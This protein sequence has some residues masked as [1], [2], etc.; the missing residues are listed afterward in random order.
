MLPPT[1]TATSPR[2]PSSRPPL[3]LL[4]LALSCWPLNAHGPQ[5]AL[6]ETSVKG[7]QERGTA[8]TSA[9]TDR[10][11]ADRLSPRQPPAPGSAKA[12]TW[13]WFLRPRIFVSTVSVSYPIPF[14]AEGIRPVSPYSRS[15]VTILLISAN[16]N[17]S[18]C[19]YSTY[20]TPLTSVPW[21]RSN[22]SNH[23]AVFPV[24]PNCII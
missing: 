8:V 5:Q 2:L 6:N 14:P 3:R 18:L 21:M 4:V 7:R 19:S 9:F 24:H 13:P 1:Q 11:Q 15:H 12:L 22:T 17:T 23:L 20:E 10:R 16:T